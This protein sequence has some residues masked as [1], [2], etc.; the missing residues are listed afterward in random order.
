[1]RGDVDGVEIDQPKPPVVAEVRLTKHVDVFRHLSAAR[2]ARPGVDV[3]TPGIE[4]PRVGGGQGA[5]IDV[6]P[7]EPDAVRKLALNLD[8][9]RVSVG[10]PG[11]IDPGDI[12]IGVDAE[13][14][15]GAGD[16]A[17]CSPEAE[18]SLS[19]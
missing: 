1:M 13:L 19:P 8:L 18:P 6:K 9:A 12:P 10:K 7:V 3:G 5:S 17:G 16:L 11:V 2:A 15:A 14:V 4:P